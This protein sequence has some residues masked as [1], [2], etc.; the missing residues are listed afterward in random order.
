M[1]GFVAQ[2]GG[3]LGLIAQHGQQPGVEVNG[4]IRKRKGIGLGVP[5]HAKAPRN[6]FQRAFRDHLLPD[7]LYI[8]D[9]IRIIEDQATALKLAVHLVDLFQQ[10]QVNLGELESLWGLAGHRPACGQT[11]D[12]QH[13]NGQTQ[14][15]CAN[16]ESR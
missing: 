7:F 4:A 6:I 2:D 12:R 14:P 10:L 5:Q 11:E 13:K 15:G 9:C 1:R 8:R 16:R 3:Q